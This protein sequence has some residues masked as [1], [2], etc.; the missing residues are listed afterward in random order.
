M[1]KFCVDPSLRTSWQ[2]AG[3]QQ[4]FASRLHDSANRGRQE[5]GS[6]APSLRKKS[7]SLCPLPQVSQ[8]FSVTDR[9]SMPVERH[10]VQLKRSCEQQGSMGL[11]D[12]DSLGEVLSGL[13]AVAEA[14]GDAL[15]FELMV[16][17]SVGA[18]LGK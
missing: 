7:F 5:S 15:G 17:R 16:G 14:E 18:L 12:G 13:L 10:V 1:H 4:S 8:V 2:V 9:K 3:K 11:P 6:G